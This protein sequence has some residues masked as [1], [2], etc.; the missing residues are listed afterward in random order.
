MRLFIMS[1]SVLLVLFFTGISSKV[2]DTFSKCDYFFKR[3]SPVIPGILSD[4]VAMNSNYKIIC[5]QYN[6][7]NRFATLYDTTE[8]IPVFSAY[9]Y[10]RRQKFEKLGK[11]HWMIE[12]Q[13]ML[14]IVA[15]C[16]HG[17][18]RIVLL[19]CYFSSC[20]LTNYLKKIIFQLFIF[21][22]LNLQIMKSMCHSST[23]PAMETIT[24]TQKM[25]TP[26]IYFQSVMQLIEKLLYL[27]SHSPTVS[28]RR[29][30]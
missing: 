12:S 15:Y 2:V 20:L 27:H 1:V 30:T 19:L 26:V 11:V 18:K 17:Y 7:C 21:Y 10:T 16:F 28:H 25:C 9:K 4:S 5:Q 3:M 14:L 29:R 24:I 8:M 13:V 23:R 6:K 22:S